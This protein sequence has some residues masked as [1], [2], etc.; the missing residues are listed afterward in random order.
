MALILADSSPAGITFSTEVRP[1]L[2]AMVS[3]SP[4]GELTPFL[5]DRRLPA[6]QDCQRSRIAALRLSFDSSG[7]KLPTKPGVTWCGPHP[8]TAKQ[9]DC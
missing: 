1:L 8:A 6:E 3:K 5:A 7:C 9:I 2:S 4:S